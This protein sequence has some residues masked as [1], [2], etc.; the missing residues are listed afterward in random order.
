VDNNER[1]SV[2]QVWRKLDKN[3]DGRISKEELKEGL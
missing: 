3:A 2:Y 1:M